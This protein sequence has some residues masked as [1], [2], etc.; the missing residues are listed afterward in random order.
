M[1]RRKDQPSYV[2]IKASIY[3]SILWILEGR[4]KAVITCRVDEDNVVM[5]YKVFGNDNS[6]EILRRRSCHAI[7]D[8]IVYA[9]LDIRLGIRRA[10][11][12]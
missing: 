11:H 9:R 8:E 7:Y 3:R 4:K 6:V 1:I 2:G 10:C 5:R 12:C